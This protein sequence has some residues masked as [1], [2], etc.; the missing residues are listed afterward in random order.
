VAGRPLVTGATGFAGSHLLEE[1]LQTHPS[2][3][4]WANPGGLALPVESDARIEWHKVDL[5]DP[6]AVTDALA[7]L[8]PDAIYHCAGLAHVGASWND[9][10]RALRV[11]AVGTHHLLDA[12]R[13]AG[14]LCPVLIVGSALVYQ[15]STSA[16]AED[17][18]LQPVT[19]YGVSKLAQEMLGWR[20]ADL[21]VFIAR[22]FNHA[23]PRQSH[24]Y[25]TSSFARQI[26]EIEARMSEPVLRVGNL[27]S[28]RDITDVRDTV[29]AYR[30]IVERGQPHRPYNV[31]AG[32]AYRVGDLL[33]MLLSASRTR[34]KLE[35]DASRMRPS[36]NPVILGD[37]SRIAAEVGWEPVIPIER[38]LSDL[39]EYWRRVTQSTP[40]RTS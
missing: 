18:R 38:T 3:A 26:A 29:R 17:H 16:L 39:L 30:L 32:R 33:E 15:Q 9:P 14:H 8:R 35:K 24:D 23:G 10:S 34:V 2:V 21:P 36:D 37:R 12:L 25:V 1:L 28:R 22:A 5:L 27:S 40:P 20:S 13:R 6:H 19:P 31:C 7:S 4:A 11:N